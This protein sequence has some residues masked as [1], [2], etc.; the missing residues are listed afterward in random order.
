MQLNKYNRHVLS[1]LTT[2]PSFC[3][4]FAFGGGKR[5]WEGMVGNR[6]IQLTIPGI[7][8]IQSR[9]LKCVKYVNLPNSNVSKIN[10]AST[11]FTININKTYFIS[12][13]N[14]CHIFI[15]TARPLVLF[16]VENI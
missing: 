11:L 10:N 16:L 7:K 15:I 9:I 8:E 14:E 4:I 13:F 6:R 1:Q 2:L 3:P 5:G 12:I